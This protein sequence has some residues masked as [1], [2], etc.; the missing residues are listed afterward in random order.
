MK[1][2]IHRALAVAFLLFSGLT[3]YGQRS[4]VPQGGELHPNPE[5]VP[6]LTAEDYNFY[7]AAVAQNIATLEAQNKRIFNPNRASQQVLFDWP[8]AQA[9]GFDYNSTWAISNYVDHNASF[10]NQI[11]DWDCGT[12]SY[13]TG[14]GYNHQGIDIYTWPFWWKQ[15]DDDQT[16]I[17]AAQAGQI[18]YKNDGSFDR[19]CA[20]NSDQWNAVY[21]E[22]SDGSVAWYGHMK[23]GSLTSKNVGDSVVIGEYLGVIG[24]SGNSTG[25]H[26]HMEVY[27]E[28]DNL[29][30]PY[31]GTCNDLNTSS[32]WSEQKPYY[33]PKINALLT[34][35]APP[36]FNFNQCGVTEVPNDSDQFTPGSDVIV[37]AYYRAQQDGTTVS[38]TVK[39]SNGDTVAAWTQDF[40]DTFGSSYWYYTVPTTSVEGV[41]EFNATYEG[42]TVTKTFNV[43]QLSVSDEAL[44][45]LE[46]YPNPTSSQLNIKA[47][48]P[49][50]SIALYDIAGR[51]LSQEQG[52]NDI[53]S[54][55]DLSP[56]AAG[57]YF[58]NVTA[59]DSNAQMTIRV[60][61]Q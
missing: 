14:G 47:A 56:Y 19:N 1:H 22:H 7:H 51:V 27:D 6:C 26:L 25:P 12:R 28:N 31:A 52:I 38:Y 40:T 8:I 41:W 50:R 11:E 60:V 53:K 49:L 44:I 4:V 58:V 29:I 46:A 43:G 61:K 36:E 32:W 57:V 5:G 20:F 9:D 21:V 30:D 33:N 37:A 35:S 55:I 10:P 23:D 24:S 15:M 39:D 3:M 17:V 34:H 45:Q 2:F 54:T 48:V 13:D 42:E 59:L 18:V 16:E